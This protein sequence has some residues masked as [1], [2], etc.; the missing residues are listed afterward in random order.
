MPEEGVE[1]TPKP[2]LLS[3]DELVRLAEMFVRQGV[4]KIRLTGGEPTVRRGVVELVG[5]LNNLRQY[6]LRSI[7]M[8]SNGIALRRTLPRLVENGLNHLNLSLDTLDPFK[9][10]IMTRRRGHAAVLE[11]LEVA[12]SSGL[13]SVKLNVVVIKDLNDSEV[14]D[15][16]EI[17]RQQDV[18][19][20]FIEFMPFAGNKWDKGRMVPSSV[21]LSDLQKRYPNIIKAVDEPNDTARSYRIPEYAGS[22]GFISSMSD[23]FCSS[24]NRL[25]LTADGQI[26]V[27]LFDAKE[28][29]LRD[30]LRGGASDDVLMQTVAVAVRGKKERHAGMEGIDVT[31]NRPMTLIGG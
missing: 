13:E 29:S 7:G 31:V 20:R 16:V 19:V 8:T 9:F 22:F 21:L 14:P 15:F 4:T 26:K 24:C 17:T 11:T 10:E 28:T 23:H 3:D 27:C 12:L 2:H 6:G 30:L 5:R 1:L 18:S 25:R